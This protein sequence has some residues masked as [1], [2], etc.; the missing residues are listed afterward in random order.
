M[1]ALK[2]RISRAGD[3]AAA[4]RGFTLVEIAIV[5]V[6]IGLLVGIGASVMG[7]L[8]KRTKWVTTREQIRGA[9]EALTGYAISRGRLPCPD[10]DGD[11]AENSP[12]ATPS[13]S[14]LPFGSLGIPGRDSWGRA[15][16]Y[17]VNP[18]FTTL[19]NQR[20]FCAYLIA[21]PSIGA[22]DPQVSDGTVTYSLPGVLV[23]AGMRDQ[24]GDNNVLD[25][26]NVPG[27]RTY[28]FETRLE[29][30]AYDD[31]VGELGYGALQGKMCQAGDAAISVSFTGAGDASY[32]TGATNCVAVSAAS[33]LFIP[34][35]NSVW[36]DSGCTVGGT[37]LYDGLWGG[38]C[39][40]SLLDCDMDRDGAI[41]YSLAT[42]S[43]S[44]L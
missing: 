2:K 31:L 18:V 8:A 29:D 5:L 9:R 19:S 26:R 35:N 43:L 11:G 27:D 38:G 17:D 39:A 3:K 34:N 37:P 41:Q 1:T 30:P 7:P 44:D 13:L 12:C 22:P 24:G 10:T 15:L 36:R 4:A 33:V 6:I 32:G 40:S 28:D 25:G 16:F 21:F 14:P 42:D 23:S 20:A